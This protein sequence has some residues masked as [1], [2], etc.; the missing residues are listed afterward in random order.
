M[1][2]PLIMPPGHYSEVKDIVLT[3]SPKEVLQ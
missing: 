3:F 1:S 2:S